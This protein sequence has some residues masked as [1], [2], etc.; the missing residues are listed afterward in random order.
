MGAC[1]KNGFHGSQF[2][3]LPVCNIF[4]GMITADRL[5][6]RSYAGKKR[7]DSKCLC[8]EFDIFSSYHHQCMHT[9][10]GKTRSRKSSQ[11]HMQGLRKPG[12]IEHRFH[13]IDIKIF[14][15][16][17]FKTCGAVHPGIR[18]NYQNAGYQT[19]D[20]NYNAGEPVKPFVEFSPSI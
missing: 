8:M 3:R 1:F 2:S 9:R 16:S 20:S 11:A 19:T 6:N 10:N 4:G 17:K 13:R 5:E 7:C 12:I 18:G 15:V 14:S